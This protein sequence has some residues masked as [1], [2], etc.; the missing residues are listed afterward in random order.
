MLHRDP[1]RIASPAPMQ[2]AQA[3]YVSDHRV[4]G[5]PVLYVEKI[6]PLAEDILFVVPFYTQSLFQMD[7]AN[8]LLQDL[9]G[10]FIYS[11]WRHHIPEL[12]HVSGHRPDTRVI[13]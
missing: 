7:L 12:W 1:A 10:C 2:Q 3:Q 9:T 5:I 4:Y 11:V 13:T 8:P 6:T